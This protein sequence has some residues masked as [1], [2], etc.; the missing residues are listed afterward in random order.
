[1]RY[2]TAVAPVLLPHLAGHPVTLHRFPDG[3]DGPHFF[4][5][6][7]PSHP[8]W[9]R[10]VT[11][12]SPNDKVFDVVVVDDLPGLV[13][14]A[15]VAAIELHPYL[16]TA[17]RF[18]APTQ[19]V[20]DLDPGAPAGLAACC[21]V[22]LEVRDLLDGLG[23]VA[24]PKA[25]GGKG[26]HVHVPVDGADFARTKAFARAVAELVARR[27]PD[28]VVTNMSKAVRAGKVFIDWGQN[29]PWRSTVAPWSVRGYAVPTVALP[30]TW[31]LVERV[32][33]TG[34]PDG[35]LVLAGDV[36]ALLDRAGDPFAALVG[37]R[38]QLPAG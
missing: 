31:E 28:L 2:Y 30:V 9:V 29:D 6:R 7:A 4:Q 26:V 8:D 33:A 17:E 38:Q 32:A 3:V 24:G 27:M 37:V 34:R 1:V 5:T 11:L 18:D 23:L 36:P 16:G 10:A 15:N 19:V 14:A 25:S 22:A 21:A 13:W 20:F 35:L 12:R